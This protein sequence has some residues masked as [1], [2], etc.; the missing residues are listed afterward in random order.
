MASVPQ[1]C[2]VLVVGGGPAGS[3][4]S[5]ALAREGIDVVLLE[6]EK[7]PRY[8]IGESMLPSMRHFLKFIDGYEKW[9]AHGFNVKENLCIL[10]RD[11]LIII[12][13]CCR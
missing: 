3:Y 8:H 11:Q 7:F 4:A 10:S 1:S 12:F 6:A 9:D 13:R 2:T 5:A